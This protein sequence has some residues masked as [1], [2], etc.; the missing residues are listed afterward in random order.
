MRCLFQLPFDMQAQFSRLSFAVAEYFRNRRQT[1]TS[2]GV[3]AGCRSLS[4][5]FP[6]G[7]TSASLFAMVGL[8][9][10]S[11]V[12]CWFGRDGTVKPPA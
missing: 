10:F 1:G 3:C 6:H 8:F 12:S 11:S 4:N 2:G 9:F 7:N 5:G